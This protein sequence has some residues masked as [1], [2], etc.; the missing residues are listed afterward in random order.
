MKKIPR[1][2]LLTLTVLIILLSGAFLIHP[3]NPGYHG[4]KA[5]GP[6]ESWQE[7]V[8][9]STGRIVLQSLQS[10]LLGPSGRQDED[11]WIVVSSDLSEVLAAIPH[12]VLTLHLSC[13]GIDA[14]N[15]EMSGDIQLLQAF[16]SLCSEH[17]YVLYERLPA[18]ERVSPEQG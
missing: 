17:F 7:L 12:D 9:R 10:S 14:S 16:A 18:N 5:V 1:R 2:P 4:A 6:A 13:F 15:I 11:G 3:F 8:T